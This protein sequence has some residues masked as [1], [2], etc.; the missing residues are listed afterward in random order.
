MDQSLKLRKAQQLLQ[1]VE[2]TIIAEPETSTSIP[3]FLIDLSSDGVQVFQ[4]SQQS[5]CIPIMVTVHGI[6]VSPDSEPTVLRKRYPMIVGI[7]HGSTKPTAKSLMN[8]VLQELDRLSPDNT[9]PI[10]TRGREF[11][12]TVRC[13]IADWPFRSYLKKVKGHSGY[14][15]CERCI[16]RGESCSVPQARSSKKK[17]RQ[18][19]K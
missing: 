12:V 8:R 3:H 6:C 7:A 18:Q 17:R 10:Q 2:A 19:F 9:D 14:W 5:E 13:V 11:T 1:R 4:N 16:Q 15:S